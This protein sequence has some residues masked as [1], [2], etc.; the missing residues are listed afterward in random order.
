MIE[1]TTIVAEAETPEAFVEDRL[2]F[3]K[4]FTKATTTAAT[5]VV[6]ILVLL[7]FFTL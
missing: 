3:W 1:K 5:V 7:A 2:S 4:W 6:V